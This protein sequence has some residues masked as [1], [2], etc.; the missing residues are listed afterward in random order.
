MK[1]LGILILFSLAILQMKAEEYV[2]KGRVIDMQDQP[3]ANAKVGADP[4][5]ET[6]VLT[7]NNGL[8]TLKWNQKITK[9]FVHTAPA[10][11]KSFDVGN[12][13]FLEIKILLNKKVILLKEREAT[14]ISSE[15]L[16]RVPAVTCD[17]VSTRFSKH[18]APA[19]MVMAQPPLNT[20]GYAPIEENGYRSTSANPLSTFSIDVDRASYSNVRRFIN[21]GSLPPQDAVR[22]EEMINY[23]SY[24]YA[25]QQGSAPVS[26]NTE[27]ALAPWVPSHQLMQIGIKARSIDKEHLPPSNWVFLIDVSGSMQTPNK[28]PLLKSALNMLVDELREEDRV[29]IVVYTGAAGAVLPSTSGADKESI[30][31][32]INRLEAGGSTAGGAGIKLAYQLA[33]ETLLDEGNNRIILASDGDFNVGASSDGEMKSLIESKRDKGIYLTVLGF[34]M[35]NYKDSKM[36]VLADH[37]NGNYAYIDNLSEAKKT[38]V[39]EFGATLFTVAKDVKIQVEFNP[40]EVAEYRLIGYENRLLNE[41][42]FNDDRKDAGEMGAGHVITALY[43]IIPVGQKTATNVDPLKYQPE[44]LVLPAGQSEGEMATVKVRYKEPDQDKSQKIETVVGMTDHFIVDANSNLQW[45][46][47]MAGFGMLLRNSEFG[48]KQYKDVISL[49]HSAVGDDPNGYRL[50]AVQLME[51]AAKLPKAEL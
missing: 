50:E 16:M 15:E 37:G 1:K 51:L 17:A 40:A 34:G 2:L 8:F 49:A 26:I 7:D 39:N 43:E 25:E 41:E 6:Y 27:V 3:V 38:L 12:K 9:V 42:D 28:L 5:F 22:I 4:K 30:K 23:F 21:N 11:V 45:S 13:T 24:D 44:D 35:G 32:A 36:E 18:G 46:A 31:S 48:P 10:Q 47:A 20:E 19:G 14:V 33:E 29:A